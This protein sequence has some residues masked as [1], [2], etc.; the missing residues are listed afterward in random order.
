ML[1]LHKVDWKALQELRDE[2]EVY[3]YFARLGMQVTPEE[4]D[5]LKNFFQN[6]VSEG[7]VLTFSQLDDVAGGGGGGFTILRQRSWLHGSRWEVNDLNCERGGDLLLITGQ[8]FWKKSIRIS[9]SELGIHTAEQKIPE[10]SENQD[11]AVASSSRPLNIDEGQRYQAASSSKP[12]EMK[13]EDG[14]N[15]DARIETQEPQETTLEIDEHLNG[16]IE[17]LKRERDS[18]PRYLEMIPKEMRALPKTLPRFNTANE[19]TTAIDRIKIFKEKINS[20]HTEKKN[21]AQ[22]PIDLNSDEDRSVSEPVEEMIQTRN[23]L[24]EEFEKIYSKAPKSERQEV[25][26]LVIKDLPNMPDETKAKFIDEAWGIKGAGAGIM[27]LKR[28]GDRIGTT[29]EKEEGNINNSDEFNDDA[30][31]YSTL[32]KSMLEKERLH[33]VKGIIGNVIEDTKKNKDAQILLPLYNTLS[34]KLDEP[35]KSMENPYLKIDHDSRLEMLSSRF[36]DEEKYDHQKAFV[37]SKRFDSQID[38]ILKNY[39]ADEP[40]S[41]METLGSLRSIFYDVFTLNADVV[42]A[43]TGYRSDIWINH[44]N[45][46]RIGKVVSAVEKVAKKENKNMGEF[47]ASLRTFDPVSKEHRLLH[48]D[49]IKEIYKAMGAGQTTLTWFR[50][51]FGEHGEGNFFAT[52]HTRDYEDCDPFWADFLIILSDPL[53][54]AK[55]LKAINEMTRGPISVGS[56]HV[57]SPRAQQ[58]IQQRARE[59]GGGIREVIFHE[60]YMYDVENE[61]Q[62]QNPRAVIY[63]HVFADCKEQGGFVLTGAISQEERRQRQLALMIILSMMAPMQ[64]YYYIAHLTDN[65][66]EIGESGHDPYGNNM[67]VIMPNVVEEEIEFEDESGHR[68]RIPIRRNLIFCAAA[69]ITARDNGH[70]KTVGGITLVEYSMNRYGLSVDPK[71]ERLHHPSIFGRNLIAE[72]KRPLLIEDAR[73]LFKVRWLSLLNAAI[74]ANATHLLTGLFGCGAFGNAI[75]IAM[76]TLE[77]CLG[78]E[79]PGQGGITYGQVVQ[80]VLTGNQEHNYMLS[81]GTVKHEVSMKNFIS[82]QFGGIKGIEKPGVPPGCMRIAPPPLPRSTPLPPP[83]PQPSSIRKQNPPL[84]SPTLNSS[85]KPAGIPTNSSNPAV[86]LPPPAPQPSTQLSSQDPRPQLPGPGDKP[87]SPTKLDNEAKTP[88]ENQENKP[89]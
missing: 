85:S 25:T 88:S 16:L 24:F 17:D 26:K 27:A 29:L 18:L 28:V 60:K 31:A 75:D 36:D 20:S 86:T 73:E 58:F 12:L 15:P 89:R 64:A 21:S 62:K 48:E 40:S 84:P 68:Y 43:Q 34:H 44:M 55:Y 22:V 2:R 56:K 30:S 61:I 53:E 74:E 41:R 70:T 6:V 37:L 45:P 57:F 3:E 14:I 77:E 54:F 23:S 1:D 72:D 9:A 79:I 19:Y 11:R 7:N 4:I 42:E 76:G 51:I 87:A 38:S 47:I 59:N 13:E 81:N 32:Y 71:E 63:S 83:A 49:W 10:K 65:F 5:T 46:E 8:S 69:D 39:K 80:V 66:V 82:P 35:L 52:R 50:F 33:S 78:M 67:A